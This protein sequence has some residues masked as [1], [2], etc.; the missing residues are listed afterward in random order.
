MAY[1][2]ASRALAALEI[3][4]HWG[5][6]ATELK[7]VMAAVEIPDRVISTPEFGALPAGWD[8]LPSSPTSRKFGA[9]WAVSLN[10]LAIALPS[11]IIPEEKI[12][13]L[14]VRHPDISKIEIAE[15]KPFQFDPRLGGK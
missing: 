4:V 11:A 9:D 1:L 6:Q 3:F 7:W 12:V 8:S 14:N 13:L 15:I 10:S 5:R 2:S